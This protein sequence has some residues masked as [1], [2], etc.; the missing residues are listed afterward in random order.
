[1]QAEHLRI[2]VGPGAV[3][4]ERYGHGG[5][6]FV[7]LHGFGTSSFLWRNVAPTLAEAGHTAYAIDLFG[8]GESDRPFDADFGVAAQAEYVDAAMTALRLPTATVVGIDLGGAIAMRLAAT[9]PDRV[10]RLVLI[11]PIAFDQ[12][13]SGDVDELHRNAGLRMAIRISRGILGAAPLLRDLLEKAVADKDKMP[14]RLL[15]RYLAPYVG[16]EGLEH[17]LTLARSIDEEDM[18]DV[19][20]RSIAQPA[21][22]VWGEQDAWLGPKFADRL[23][24]TL[25]D[26]RLVR[27]PNA[28]RL[29]PEE[30]AD[31]LAN[32][33]LAFIGVRVGV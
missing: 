30:A 31:T 32:L 6:A 26:N 24:S 17:L 14:D 2:P 8:Y 9:K 22:I 25:P 1:M 18:E 16:K 15:A 13:P 27:V 29:V 10:E 5:S 12:I 7:L 4:V 21:L 11:N 33:I 23:A 20:L 19:D 3:H 28:G